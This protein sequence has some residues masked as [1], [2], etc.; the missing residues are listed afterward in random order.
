MG[1]GPDEHMQT[2]FRL[3]L[4]A[5]LVAAAAASIADRVVP[6]EQF[7][8]QASEQEISDGEEPLLVLL[9]RASGGG[10]RG[11]SGRVGGGGRG[12]SRSRNRSLKDGFRRGLHVTVESSKRK[13]KEAHV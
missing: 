6:E 5:G 1:V 2:L 13:Q 9:D 8:D 12:R 7:Y 3:L 11:K 4:V 10:G